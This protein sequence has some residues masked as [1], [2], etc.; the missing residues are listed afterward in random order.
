M[1]QLCNCDCDC[2]CVTVTVAAIVTFATNGAWHAKCKCNSCI[3]LN[4]MLRAQSSKSL[5]IETLSP[6]P[7]CPSIS[8][9]PSLDSCFLCAPLPSVTAFV[10]LVF[11]YFRPQQQL[12][13][14]LP[15]PFAPLRTH[16]QVAFPCL[17]S[18]SLFICPSTC[19]NLKLHLELGCAPTHLLAFLCGNFFH[20]STNFRQEF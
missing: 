10:A 6:P 18:L 3:L 4:F 20:I 5:A 17:P 8:V 15:D 12:Q 13:F 2:D 14:A 9:H 11:F 7:H 1:G 16:T 19:C